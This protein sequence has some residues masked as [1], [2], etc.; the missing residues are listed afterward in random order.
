[1][2]NPAPCDMIELHLF[3]GPNGSDPRWHIPVRYS[4]GP[5]IIRDCG[6]CGRAVASANT[7]FFMYK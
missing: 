4:Y 5:M 2:R 6:E 7:R 1:M 3:E